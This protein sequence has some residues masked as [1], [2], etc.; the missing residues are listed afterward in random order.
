METITRIPHYFPKE[1]L[2]IGYVRMLNQ[3]PGGLHQHEFTEIAIVESGTGL[4]QFNEDVLPVCGGE[5][6]VIN[7]GY[8]HRWVET[9]NLVVTN[10]MISDFDSIIGLS[11]LSIH[12]GFSALFTFEPKMRSSQKGGGKLKLDIQTLKDV[13]ALSSRLNSSLN[14]QDDAVVTTSTSYLLAIISILCDNY[15]SS[16]S[17]KHERVLKVGGM[18][19]YL[20]E[21]WKD[22]LDI[23]FL[24]KKFHLSKSNLHRLF[25][26]AM[27]TTP[28]QYISRLRIEKG[29]EFLRNTDETI[30]RIALNVGFNDSNYFTRTFLKIKGV[31]PKAYRNIENKWANH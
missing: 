13:C 24:A 27:G 25:R 4:H 16:P 19:N 10:L 30:T 26:K 22:P 23:D 5:V 11:Q 1:D 28:I 15:V 31:T 8:N 2:P 12:P 9:E 14:N 17:Q 20:D 29:C 3:L 7:N 21:H 18:V 6:F